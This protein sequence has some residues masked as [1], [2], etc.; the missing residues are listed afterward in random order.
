MLIL[1]AEKIFRDLFPLNEWCSSQHCLF[2][3]L[4]NQ[5]LAQTKERV[6]LSDNMVANAI[7]APDSKTENIDTVEVKETKAT[8]LKDDKKKHKKKRNNDVDDFIVA[9]ASYVGWKQVG[10]YENKDELTIEDLLDETHQQTF[11][12]EFYRK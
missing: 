12:V 6:R 9:E 2:L 7:K 4:A 8:V 5:C 10:G 3:Y 11:W 1:G